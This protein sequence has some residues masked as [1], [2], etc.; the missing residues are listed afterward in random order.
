SY[1]K[2]GAIPAPVGGLGDYRLA[3]LDS[4]HDVLDVCPALFGHEAVGWIPHHLG[5]RVA[6][7]QF[8]PPVDLQNDRRDNGQVGDEDAD[9]RVFEQAAV[10]SLA[11][12]AGAVRF[13]VPPAADGPPP[14][15]TGCGV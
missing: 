9:G 6:V 15:H 5:G 8:R 3:S 11:A 12:V 2:S 7:D 4:L 1:G 14:N 13:G 10:A